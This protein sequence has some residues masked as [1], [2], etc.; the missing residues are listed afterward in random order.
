MT[1]E[2]ELAALA[3]ARQ[4]GFLGLA[5]VHCFTFFVR[6]NYQIKNQTTVCACVLTCGQVLIEGRINYFRINEPELH[7]PLFGL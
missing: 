6:E 5:S 4:G 2:T 7:Q 1:G 3:L